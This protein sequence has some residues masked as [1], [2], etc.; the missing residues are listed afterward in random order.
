MFQINRESEIRKMDYTITFYEEQGFSDGKHLQNHV[1]YLCRTD[2]LQKWTNE[3]TEINIA[4]IFDDG[5]TVVPFGNTFNSRERLSVRI[6]KLCGKYNVLDNVRNLRMVRAEYK[7]S[8]I[9]FFDDTMLSDLTEII[10]KMMNVKGI[11][12]ITVVT[13]CDQKQN[14][15][16][17]HMLYI[18][19]TSKELVDCL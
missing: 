12:P 15:T 7:N 18:N 9:Y 4:W 11:I 16:H 6:M 10:V 19:N 14:Y 17:F 5:D 2:R 1:N 13:H 8:D 3:L